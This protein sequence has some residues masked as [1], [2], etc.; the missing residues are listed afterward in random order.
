[1]VKPTPEK[2]TYSNNKKRGNLKNRSHNKPFHQ[3]KTEK[4]SLQFKKPVK[5]S[6]NTEVEKTNPKIQKK[7]EQKTK[8]KNVYESIKVHIKNKKKNREKLNKAIIDAIEYI[9]LKGILLMRLLLGTKIIQLCLK[10]GSNEQRETLLLLTMKTDL[11]EICKNPYSSFIIEKIFKYVPNSKSLKL[12]KSFFSKNFSNLVQ[13]KENFRALNAYINLFE[14]KNHYKMI[15]ENQKNF[16]VDE[17]VLN[18]FIEILEKRFMFLHLSFTYYVIFFNYDKITLENKQGLVMKILNDL[19][20]GMRNN[21]E[22][23][24]MLTLVNKLFL[25]MNMKFKKEIIKKLFTGDFNTFYKMNPNIIYLLF[26]L[27]RKIKDVKVINVTFL[28]NMKKNYQDFFENINFAKFFLMLI[29]QDFLD[30]LQKEKVFI[31]NFLTE[32]IFDLKTLFEEELFLKN[33]G[34][35]KEE[36]LDKF[37]IK[38][39]LD[40]EKIKSSLEINSSFSQLY[41]IIISELLQKDTNF[42]VISDFFENLAENIKNDFIEKKDEME[43]EDEDDDDFNKNFDTIKKEEDDKFIFSTNGHRFIKYLIQTLEKS[44]SK[45]RII[46]E[47]FVAELIIVIKN[48]YKKFVDSKGVFVLIGI[49]ENSKHS[50][51]L[52]EFLKKNLKKNSLDQTKKGSK[53]LLEK[54]N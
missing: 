50:E 47:K 7:K 14:K 54:L 53:I 35:I 1:M 26:T 9:Q 32:S 34:Y 10:Y 39:F 49:L 2:Q 25:D 33:L 18:E 12:L 27:L 22:N 38:E 17:F 46:L 36:L 29:K 31:T 30:R 43:I 48:N 19:M 45:N 40:Y 28:K 4:N 5:A 11:F 6:P 24:I 52:K 8:L 3:H 21:N 23:F 41:S 37:L 51:D 15:L 20:K 42:D 44:G 16:D 13:N